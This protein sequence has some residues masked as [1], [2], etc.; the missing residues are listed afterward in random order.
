MLNRRFIFSLI[1]IFLAIMCSLY[2]ILNI[3]NNENR[4]VGVLV[5]NT[6]YSYTSPQ[7]LDHNM[8]DLKKLCSEPVYNQLTIDNEERTLNTYLKFKG[9]PVAVH[10]IKEQEGVI[11]YNLETRY[12][13]AERQFA[14]VYKTNRGKISEVTEYEVIPF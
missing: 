13:S 12:I 7:E 9:E 10:I 8:V 3:N 1:A 14:F 11:I 4:S 6:L 5:V 2:L